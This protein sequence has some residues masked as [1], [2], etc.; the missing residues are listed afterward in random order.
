LDV[1]FF[2]MEAVLVVAAFIVIGIVCGLRSLA[3][4]D[5]SS[6]LIG[7]TAIL[8]IVFAALMSLSLGRSAVALRDLDFYLALP[9]YEATLDRRLEVPAG[10][11]YLDFGTVF[12]LRVTGFSPDPYCGYEYA[13][14]PESIVLDPLGSG[15]GIAEPLPVAGWYWI[16]AS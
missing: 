4:P 14:V 7:G 11:H 10:V 6:P 13:P 16:C 2:V 15:E 3:R 8:A 1:W 9:T 12:F 5:G